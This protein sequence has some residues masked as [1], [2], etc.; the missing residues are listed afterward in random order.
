MPY[1]VSGSNVLHY[2]GGKWK[3]KQ[4]CKSPAAAKRAISLLRGV[5]HGMKP[6]KVKK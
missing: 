4:H 6:R 2:K 3:V 5:E 1:R